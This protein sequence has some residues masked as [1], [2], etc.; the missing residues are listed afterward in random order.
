VIEDASGNG[1]FSIRR[2]EK[3]LG[4]NRQFHLD[5]YVQCRIEAA[6]FTRRFNRDIHLLPASPF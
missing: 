5:L 3:L 2:D 1:A 4:E 6:A